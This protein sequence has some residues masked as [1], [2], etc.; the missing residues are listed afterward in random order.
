M[1]EDHVA[2]IIGRAVTDAAFRELLFSD[3]EEALKEYV[4][5]AEEK[6]ALMQIKQED[7]EEFG[8]KL[9][10]RITKSKIW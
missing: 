6:E 8:G 10:K 9:D 2:Q 3:L 1:A 4:L 5:T 7:L